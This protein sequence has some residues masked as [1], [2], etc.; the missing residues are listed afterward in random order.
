MRHERDDRMQ[1][2]HNRVQRHAAHL[3]KLHKSLGWNLRRNRDVQL[4]R[5]HS[6]QLRGSL[7]DHRGDVH[8]GRFRWL[9]AGRHH[10]LHGHG[11][12]VQRSASF[13][14]ADVQRPGR[15]DVLFGRHLCLR[16]SYADEL[17]GDL[18]EHR[19]RREQLPRLRSCLRGTN[20]WLGRRSL[21]LH[22]WCLRAAVHLGNAVWQR[23]R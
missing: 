23:L 6:E 15:R 4:W 7:P 20:E 19:E 8:V 10:R 14:R 5:S 2:N 9:P 3:R 1:W 11:Y 22:E 12:D 16:G 17:L 13:R 21:N 18:H